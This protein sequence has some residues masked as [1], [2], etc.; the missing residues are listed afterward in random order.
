MPAAGCRDGTERKWHSAAQ[1][2]RSGFEL[3][4]PGAHGSRSQRPRETT[5]VSEWRQVCGGRLVLPARERDSTARGFVSRVPGEIRSP[6]RP[7]ILH[8]WLDY[9]VRSDV[10]VQTK[11]AHCIQGCSARVS[12]LFL[13]L[14]I[15]NLRMVCHSWW[16]N[17]TECIESLRPRFY[18][19]RDVGATF[20]RLKRLDFGHWNVVSV[21]L[22]AH[23]S[24]PFLKRGN[25]PRW[26]SAVAWTALGRIATL[27]VWL[28]S[29]RGGHKTFSRL[30]QPYLSECNCSHYSTL[31][32]SNVTIGL[33]R[34]RIQD[35]NSNYVQL[36]T[37]QTQTTCFPQKPL[38]LLQLRESCFYGVKLYVQVYLSSF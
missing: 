4:S 1:G 26:Y 18:K 19:P 12:W 31:P 11:F 6:A 34:N 30:F 27:V 37:V 2:G 14:Q 35:P 15:R 32:I 25:Q 10:S 24:L 13:V 23:R 3:S 16:V 9:F 38:F 28:P 8:C 33:R 29:G 5:G 17:V 36:L 22:S 21:C 20:P 7:T